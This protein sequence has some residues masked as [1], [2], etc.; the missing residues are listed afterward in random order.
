MHQLAG[1]VFGPRASKIP[2]CLFGQGFAPE[3]HEFPRKT[4]RPAPR[5]T[6]CIEVLNFV[7]PRAPSKV[8]YPAPH[9]EQGAARNIPVP[10]FCTSW[11]TVCTPCHCECKHWGPAPR[12]QHGE[13][14]N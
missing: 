6:S 4:P 1:A 2:L 5:A 8:P 12:A 3:C 13:R 14:R 7:P 10:R 9:L 11:K